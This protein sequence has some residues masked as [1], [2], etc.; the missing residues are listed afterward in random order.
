LATSVK[1]S[2]CFSGY[3][4]FPVEESCLSSTA[5]AAALGGRYPELTGC[6]GSPSARAVAT[7]T[8]TE[9]GPDPRSLTG[10]PINATGADARFRLASNIGLWRLQYGAGLSVA[11][12]S[13]TNS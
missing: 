8:V 1:K 13:K 3:A 6:S 4:A 10:A 5:R 2:T 11:S 9:T 12:L 7:I